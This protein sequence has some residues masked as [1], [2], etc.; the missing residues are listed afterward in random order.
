MADDGL[1]LPDLPCIEFVEL[2]TDYLEGALSPS[3]RAL[4][5]HHL[6][7]CP[8]CTTVLAQWREVIA[9]TGRLEEHEVDEIDPVVRQELV[10][11]F[12]RTYPTSP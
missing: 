10:A 3:R 2:V 11:A 12:C 4:V 7:I 1:A 5:D 8:G 9:L 6:E